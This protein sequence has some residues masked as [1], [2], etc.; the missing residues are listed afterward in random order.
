MM[1]TA[2][3]ESGYEMKAVLSVMFNSDFFKNARFAKIKSPAEVVASTLRLSG[4]WELPSPN[5]GHRLAARL[6]GPVD[7]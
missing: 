2:F 7:P 1:M 5:Q 6:H 4:S 3:E